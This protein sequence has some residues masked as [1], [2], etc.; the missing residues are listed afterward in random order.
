[1]NLQQKSHI[2]KVRNVHR[3]R[4]KLHRLQVWNIHMMFYLNRNVSV[5]GVW[6]YMELLST[7]RHSESHKSMCS[8]ICCLTLFTASGELQFL[9]SPEH[10]KTKK[11]FQYLS[12]QFRHPTK[13]EDGY[14]IYLQ[15]SLET[16]GIHEGHF[17]DHSCDNSQCKK[18]LCHQTLTLLNFFTENICLKVNGGLQSGDE[19]CLDAWRHGSWDPLVNTIL[20]AAI[21]SPP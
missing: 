3:R 7:P 1:M 9:E 13:W 11:L 6:L 12:L 15:W 19:V 8:I 4:L 16:E 5:W 21:L 18:A 14:Y 17:H 10:K 20:V 2:K